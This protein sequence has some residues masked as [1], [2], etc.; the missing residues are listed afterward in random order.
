MMF[1]RLI[2]KKGQRREKI[3]LLSVFDMFV[4]EGGIVEIRILRFL[5]GVEFKRVFLCYEI[6]FCIFNFNKNYS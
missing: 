3:C 5:N 6:I 2:E 4:L 1:I